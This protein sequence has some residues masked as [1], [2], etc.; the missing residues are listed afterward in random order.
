MQKTKAMNWKKNNWTYS[1]RG[2][3][4]K[5]KQSEER[6]QELQDTKKT[7]TICIMEIP[8]E[9]EMERKYI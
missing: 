4:K 2:A 9:K 3:M 7:S 8:G 1:I 6:L 5:K